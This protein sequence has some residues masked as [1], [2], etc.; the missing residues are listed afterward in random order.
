M[1]T[2]SNLE[3]IRRVPLFAFLTPSQADV[4]AQAVVKRRFRRGALVMRQ[5]ERSNTLFIILTDRV[6]VVAADQRGRE[7]TLAIRQAGH[8]IGEMSLIDKELH[9][10]TVRAEVQT[11]MLALGGAEFTHCLQASPSMA[12]ALLRG[13]VQN[14]RQADRKIASFAFMDVCGRVAR[15]LLELAVTDSLAAFPRPHASDDD[16][17][18]PMRRTCRMTSRRPARTWP[19]ARHSTLGA[20]RSSSSSCPRCGCLGRTEAGASRKPC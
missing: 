6:R 19:G 9:S 12:Y 18:V 4:V 1:S 3:L 10:A 7:V 2:L 13:L 20:C 14:L 5:G 16:S 11:D 17:L 15:A 8:H